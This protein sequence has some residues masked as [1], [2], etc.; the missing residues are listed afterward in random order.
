M[1][2]TVPISTSFDAIGSLKEFFY[3]LRELTLYRKNMNNDKRLSRRQEIIYSNIFSTSI[4]KKFKPY[5]KTIL[6]I[7]SNGSRISEG[8][9]CF[10]NLV[11][12]LNEYFVN[13]IVFRNIEILNQIIYDINHEEGRDW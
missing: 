6:L 1:N 11:H 10:E 7:F 5:K 13:D 3:E 9:C 12:F 4:I 2:R 8:I